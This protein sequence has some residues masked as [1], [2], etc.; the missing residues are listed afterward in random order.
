MLNTRDHLIWVHHTLKEK[1]VAWYQRQSITFF[2][3]KNWSP[4]VLLFASVI[5]SKFSQ[6]SVVYQGYCVL[7]LT[8]IFEKSNSAT[9]HF[10]WEKHRT[11]DLKRSQSKLKSHKSHLHYFGLDTR[12][13][14]E[15]HRQCSKWPPPICTQRRRRR[16]MFLTTDLHMSRSTSDTIFRTYSSIR[17]TVAEDGVGS[18]PGHV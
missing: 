16:R 13:M 12:H 3:V 4:Y 8:L 6:K 18:W 11:H 14:V 9:R 2:S 17:K 5:L 7:A 10:Q 15:P 1:I